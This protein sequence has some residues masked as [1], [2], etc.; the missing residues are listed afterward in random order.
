[1]TKKILTTVTALIALCACLFAFTGCSSADASNFKGEWVVEG[2]SV[3]VVFT[4]DKFKTYGAEYDYTLDTSS[5]TITYTSDSMT[6]SATYSFS[7][8]NKKLTLTE[9]SDD[10]GTKSTNFEK[11]S[12]DTSAEPVVDYD[13]SSSSDSGDSANSS[14]SSSN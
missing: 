4:G 2:T 9:A 12:D 11:V 7:D 5:H 14:S 13:S 8:D 3:T 10:G 1:M 6:G